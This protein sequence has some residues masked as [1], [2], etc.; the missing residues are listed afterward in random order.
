MPKIKLFKLFLILLLFVVTIFSINVW[1]AEPGDTPI[2]KFDVFEADI[3]EVFRSLAELDNLNV[4]MDPEVKGLVTIKIKAGLTVKEAIELLAQ[5]NGYSSRWLTANRTVLIGNEKT[6]TNFEARETRV[7]QLTYAQPEQ[8]VNTIKVLVPADQIGIDARTNQ[9]TI[10]ASILTQQNIAEIIKSLDREMAQITIDVRVEEIKKSALDKIGVNWASTDVNIDFSQ[11]SVYATAV[12]NLQLWEERSEARLL[13]NPKISTTDSQEGTIFIGDRY[14]QVITDSSQTGVTYNIQ[15]IDV[16]TKLSVTPR[17]NSDNIVTVTVK[18]NVSSISNSVAAGSNQLPVVRNRDISSVI[19]L[20]DGE[21]FILSGLNEINSLD[22]KDQVKGLGS[23]PLIG[24]LFKQQ[25]KSPNDD[26]EVCIFIT[27]KIIHTGSPDASSVKIGSDLK[28]K[29]TTEVSQQNPVPTP[30]PTPAPIAPVTQNQLPE[31]NATSADQTTPADSDK[32]TVSNTGASTL[33][34]ST[35]NQSPAQTTIS[36]TTAT[37]IT[38]S[39]QTTDNSTAPKNPVA[40][41]TVPSDSA[42]QTTTGTTTGQSQ[43]TENH[44]TPKELVIEPTAPLMT[45][46]GLKITIHLKPGDTL[47]LIAKKYGVTLASLLQENHLNSAAEMNPNLS[48]ILLIPTS[49]LYPL[50]PKETLWRLAMRYGTTV[51]ILMEINDLTDSSNLEIGQQIILPV[52]VE[53]VVNRKF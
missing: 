39:S 2:S 28:E 52:A 23:L 21:T 31:N 26:T 5:T 53:K 30:T 45:A 25:V 50:K 4:L 13:S 19:R 42:T 10:R 48:L 14:P 12:H 51:K 20:R 46:A 32:S 38:D 41:V 17:I 40:A 27:P 1:S 16:G 24:W 34:T 44:T 7:Y 43:T 22:T 11:P 29:S 36:T 37:S 15:Y 49:H 47:A 9:L 3:R 33:D 35:A 6:F 18:A 8:I